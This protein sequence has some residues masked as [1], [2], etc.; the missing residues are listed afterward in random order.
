MQHL[1]A[2]NQPVQLLFINMTGEEVPKLRGSRKYADYAISEEEWKIL[3]LIHEVLKVKSFQV[4][5]FILMI[6]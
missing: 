4:F 3:E 2:P 5:L 1:E 6:Y